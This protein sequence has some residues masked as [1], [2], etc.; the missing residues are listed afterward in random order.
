MNLWT[1]NT[2]PP[3]SLTPPAARAEAAPAM[4]YDAFL[5]LLVAEMQNQD[6]TSPMDSSD[7]IAQF[8]TFSNVEQAM[9]MNAKLDALLTSNAL[10]QAEGFIGRT[11]TSADGKIKG[12]VV[13][14]TITSDG[15]ILAKL[16]D[17]EELVVG[18]GV[19]IS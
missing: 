15:Q 13:S 8:A 19:T 7:K 12:E 4:D 5:K 17:G 3:T 6:P 14:L 2:S 9:Q 1:T 18:P 10:N 16:K 11:V